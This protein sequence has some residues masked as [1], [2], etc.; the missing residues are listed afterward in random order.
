MRQQNYGMFNMKKKIFEKA[1]KSINLWNDNQF[2]SK[3]FRAIDKYGF[4]YWYSF[5][6]NTR[7]DTVLLA[8]SNFEGAVRNFNLEFTTAEQLEN[9]FNN[10]FIAN[11]KDVKYKGHI[12]YKDVIHGNFELTEDGLPSIN[13]GE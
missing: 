5:W 6:R 1:L 13:K 10:R 4:A 11:E 3:E 9:Y 7:L 2:D 12:L 8:I